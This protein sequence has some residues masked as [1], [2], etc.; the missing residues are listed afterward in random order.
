MRA[1]TKEVEVVFK[2]QM[3]HLKRQ[4]ISFSYTALHRVEVAPELGLFTYCLYQFPVAVVTN[5]GEL[6]GLKYQKLCHLCSPGL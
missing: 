6:S 4:D 5:C 1:Q 2:S 3:M